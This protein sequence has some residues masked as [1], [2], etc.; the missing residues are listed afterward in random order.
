MWILPL[1]FKI[2]IMARVREGFQFYRPEFRDP[3]YIIPMPM[4]RRMRFLN[5]HEQ[6]TRQRDAAMFMQAKA[7]AAYQLM[8]GKNFG[9][10]SPIFQ[11][12]YIRSMVKFLREQGLDPVYT[13]LHTKGKGFRGYLIENRKNNI[14]S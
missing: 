10:L 13:K 9:V 3:K 1:F 5:K 2:Q 12:W 11:G 6:Y 14:Q 7:T 4:K 8:Q